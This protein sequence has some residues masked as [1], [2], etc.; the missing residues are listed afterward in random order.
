M[1][2]ALEKEMQ[3]YFAVFILNAGACAAAAARG[4]THARIANV[5]QTKLPEKVMRRARLQVDVPVFGC[6][7]SIEH[8]LNN[9]AQSL[10]NA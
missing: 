3:V 10:H 6:G 9:S 2:V 5:I 7:C 1:A 8:F 4:L